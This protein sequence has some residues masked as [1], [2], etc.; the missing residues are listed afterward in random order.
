MKRV[1]AWLLAPFLLAAAVALSAAGRSADDRPFFFIQ[2]SDPQFG[3]ETADADFAQETA[4]LEFA[5]A[6]AN[7]L[8][9]AFVIVTGD[10]VNK[11]GDASQV[12]EY[13]R[14]A[15][16]LD[17][18]IPL[19]NVP[20]NHDVGNTPT[21]ESVAAYVNAFG[22]DHYTF[23]LPGFVGIVVNSGL[24]AAPA[25]APVEAAAQEAWLDDALQRARAS[26]ARH[27]VLFSHHPLFINDP[28]EADEYT[29][30][31]RAVRVRLLE[32]LHAAAV[33]FVFAGHHHR[34]A[35]GRDGDLE[36]VTTGPVG[37]PLGD[38]RSGMRIVVVKGP[39]IS[40]RF[41]ELCELPNKVTP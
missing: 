29:N 5:I 8:R 40:H 41:F 11:A 27:V 21:P 13:R 1:A 26:G 38:G 15:G 24:M 22:P 16:R 31:P 9:P 3:M 28:G 19:Y 4:N 7:R 14:I 17:P 6:T 23:A 35:A 39:V 20:G 25:K 33:R 10:L 32:R 37:K 12:A 18:S 2:L 34:N 36:M 30:L